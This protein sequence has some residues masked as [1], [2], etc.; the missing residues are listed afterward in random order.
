M[1]CAACR[2]EAVVFQPYSG[3]HLCSVH[4]TKDFE[5]KAKRAIRKNRWLLPGDHTAVVLTGD[6]AQAAL[7]V[8]LYKLTKDRRDVRLSA[9]VIDEG[10]GE[11]AGCARQAAERC[12]I[13]IFA[14]SFAERYGTT[15]ERL[16]QNEG[17]A[18]TDWICRVLTGDLAAEIAAANGITRLAIATTVDDPA[19]RFFSDLLNGTVEQTLFARETVGLLKI[20]VIRPFMDIPKTEVYHYAGLAGAGTGSTGTT[21]PTGDSDAEVVLAAYDNR[22]PATKFALANL[23]GT[24]AKIAGKNRITGGTCPVCSGPL[25]NGNCFDCAVR[26]RYAWRADE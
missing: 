20:P 5:A 3:K 11:P 14:G 26:R 9:I 17:V 22:H 8:F 16:V 1:Q 21:V 23:A 15:R 6:A 7:L 19:I 13:G 24:L 12:G 10:V 25:E 4:F 2:R 18:A